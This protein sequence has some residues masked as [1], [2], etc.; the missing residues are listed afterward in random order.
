MIKK[1]N[2]RS[3]Y[4]KFCEIDYEEFEK[5]LVIVAVNVVVSVGLRVDFMGVSIGSSKKK[6]YRRVKSGSGFKVELD[7]G[8]DLDLFGCIFC[9]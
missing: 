6:G 9:S 8:N 3:K 4:I 1:K 5:V 7:L 2:K